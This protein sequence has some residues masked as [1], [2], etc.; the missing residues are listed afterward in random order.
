MGFQDRIQDL[1]EDLEYTTKQL[2]SWKK[3]S[4]P[5]LRRDAFLKKMDAAAAAEA[6]AEK[7]IA[8][9]E[10]EVRLL[11]PATPHRR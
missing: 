4:R 9:A 7:K 5:N 8:E 2:D 1:E 3:N 11:L 6:E 10:T